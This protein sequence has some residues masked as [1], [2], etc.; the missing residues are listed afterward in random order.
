MRQLVIVDRSELWKGK[1]EKALTEG[2]AQDR[3]GATITAM[4]LLRSAAAATNGVTTASS[5]SNGGSMISRPRSMRLEYDPNRTAFIAPI[6]YEDGELSY[7]PRPAAAEGGRHGHLREQGRREAGNA[8][9]L[10]N[11]RSARSCTMSR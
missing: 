1:P 4:L 9:P 2:F 7:N 6:R 3:R 5:I 10:K 11:I 8:M